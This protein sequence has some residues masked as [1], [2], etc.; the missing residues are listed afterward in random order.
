MDCDYVEVLLRKKIEKGGV[1]A[2]TY[3]F[4]GKVGNKA[5][6]CVTES[7]AFAILRNTKPSKWFVYGKVDFDG[8]AISS[9]AKFFPDLLDW[10]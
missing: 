4:S 7:H 8:G 10:G 3:G 6:E 2:A 1:S 9:L 5:M